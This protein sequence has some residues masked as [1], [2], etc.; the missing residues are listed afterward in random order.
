VRSS[1]YGC[2]A[3]FTGRRLGTVVPS[4][5]SPAVGYPYELYQPQQYATPLVVTPHEC[6]FPAA[7]D[8][9]WRL[10]AMGVGA[11]ADVVVP[12]PN[13]PESSGR[14]DDV[15]LERDGAGRV[16]HDDVDRVPNRR[17]NGHRV[18]TARFES[19]RDDA[20]VA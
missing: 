11:A 4:P 17:A 1:R 9:N 2:P 16:A 18:E 8:A 14:D 5:S 13:W 7:T 10:P 15:C 3:T 6:Q 19:H 20:S 12:S